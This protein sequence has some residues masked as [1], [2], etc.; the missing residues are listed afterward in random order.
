[1]RN[2]FSKIKL[3][4]TKDDPNSNKI[5]SRIQ[6]YHFPDTTH[7]HPT[8]V[9]WRCL[10]CRV[11]THCLPSDWTRGLS[12][13]QKGSVSRPSQCLHSEVS[14]FSSTLRGW[15]KTRHWRQKSLKTFSYSN[16]NLDHL[17]KDWARGGPAHCSGRT[18]S[19]NKNPFRGLWNQ[20]KSGI[21]KVCTDMVKNYSE[22]TWAILQRGN[23]YSKDIL[24]FINYI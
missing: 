20:T 1:M 17:D 5:K 13:W 7:R 12:Y 14:Y 23:M 2:Q 9:H 22:R 10:W 3:Y 21:W 6:V 4:P 16:G 11:S 19:E 18:G 8:C 15:I 24:K